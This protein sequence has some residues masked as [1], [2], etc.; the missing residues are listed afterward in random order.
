MGAIPYKNT[1]NYKCLHCGPLIFVNKDK[2]FNRVRNSDDSNYLQLK[3]P[4][5]FYDLSRLKKYKPK[6]KNRS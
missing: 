1:S 2:Q 4:T 6:E 5:L 3:W